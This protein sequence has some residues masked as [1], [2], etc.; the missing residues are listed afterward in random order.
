M[1]EEFQKKYWERDELDK[2]RQPDHPIIKLFAESKIQEIRKYINFDNQQK[3]LDVGAGNGFFSYYFD[4]ICQVTAVDYSEKMIELNPVKNKMVMDANNLKF[5]DNYFDI[6]FESCLLHHVENE[7]K[8]I[9]E[10]KRVSKKYLIFLEPNRSNPLIFLFGL[11][12][13][14]ERK[15]LN[16]SL[17]YLTKKIRNNNLKI[18]LA[19]SH[20]IIAPNKMPKFLAPV[21]NLFDKKIPLIGIDNLIICEKLQNKS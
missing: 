2:R 7:D 4:K 3:L 10:M 17:K 8:I 13:K 21:L 19:I 16:F 15:S 14:E 12:K 18:L 1:A 11:I 5:A 20:G 9:S 6:V